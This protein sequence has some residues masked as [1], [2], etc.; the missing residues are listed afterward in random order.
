MK[1]LA[2]TTLLVFL[3]AGCAKINDASMR[4]FSSSAP[5]LAVVD[6]TFLSGKVVV[7]TDRTGTINLESDAE[8]KLKCMG[9]LRYTATKTGAVSLK[10]SDGTDTLMSFTAISE[11][12]G[13]GRGRTAR[14]QASYT[15]GMPAADAAAYLTLPPGKRMATTPEGGARLE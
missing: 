2:L 8:P 9:N 5:A 3:L 14:G 6:S 13:Y 15:F 4:L 1:P 10:C 11:T 7:F 12:S